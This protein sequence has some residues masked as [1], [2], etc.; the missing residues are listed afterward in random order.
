[1]G[2]SVSKKAAR[3]VFAASIARTAPM[4]FSTK[5][6]LELLR[7]DAKADARVEARAERK[8]AKQAKANLTG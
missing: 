6:R 5:R 4:T 8:A 1:M 7:V 2:K 3:A